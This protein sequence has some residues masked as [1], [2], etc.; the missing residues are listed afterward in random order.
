MANKK[1]GESD[2]VT[3]M[4]RSD[5]VLI[6]VGGSTRQ[7][8]LGDL[9]DAANSGDEQALR[10]IAWGI[11]IKDTLQSSPA[12]GMVGNTQMWEEYR[13]NVGRYL[14]TNAG[15]CAK[16]NPANSAYFADGTAV[17][18]S[19]GH[20]MVM[21]PA[22]YGRVA[23]DSALG[24]SVLWLSMSPIGGFCLTNT[25]DKKWN[26]YGAYKGYMDGTALVSRSG[27][28]PTG[29][30]TISQFHTAAQVNGTDWGLVDYDGRKWMAIL[31]MCEAGGN[32][33]IQDKLG[34]GV[35]GSVAISDLWDTA[36]S[37]V[38]GA[39][40]NL[41]DATGKISISLTSTAGTTTT[42]ATRVNILGLE[43]IYGWQW[44]MTQGIYFGSTDNSSQNEE[45][46]YIYA[47]NRMPT[48]AELTSAP[49]GQYRMSMRVMTSGY[50]KIMQLGEYFD[51]LPKTVGGGSTSYWC[52]YFYQTDTGQLC[53][54][55]G[56]ANTGPSAGPFSVY[57]N[58]AFGDTTSFFGSRL[59]FYGT[60]EVTDGSRL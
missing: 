31:C 8:T 22:L 26:C 45:D 10:E 19:A 21:G 12:W 4:T 56:S 34:Y 44:E 46:A 9:L 41:G 59:A 23:E 3:T 6:T 60:P 11:P 20:V 52:D 51:I 33:N 39:T 16:L 54:F 48:S 57:S 37:R 55:G 49:L 14:M 1:L 5:M 15:R 27:Y 7:I 36:K 25:A 42:N 18:E 32:M 2:K 58:I 17:T 35:G 24:C 50:V 40:K 30:K 47:G 13:N 38:T 28:A 29:S 53:L 43:D